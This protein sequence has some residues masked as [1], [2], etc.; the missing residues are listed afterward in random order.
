MVKTIKH[1]LNTTHSP[2]FKPLSYVVFTNW[3]IIHILYSIHT[4][5]LNRW[6]MWFL[7]IDATEK[8]I[9]GQWLKPLNIF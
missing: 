3:S 8:N 5:G 2:R 6:A 4:H 9:C 7:Q 1:I